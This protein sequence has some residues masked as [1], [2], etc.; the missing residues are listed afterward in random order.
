MSAFLS[1]VGTQLPDDSPVDCT[2]P[3][4]PAQLSADLLR[5]MR[6]GVEREML[7]VQPDGFIAKTAHPPALGS[8][9]THPRIT[10]DY[11]EA[12]LELITAPVDSI[13]ALLAELTELHQWVLAQLP[14]GELLWPLSMPCLLDG[15]DEDI[16]LAQYGQAPIGRL[17]TLYRQGLGLRYGRRMQTIAGVH[18]NLSFGAEFFAALQACEPDPDLRRMSL[19]DY[20]DGRYLGLVRNFIRLTPLVIALVG[21]SPAVCACFLTGRT[22]H[23]QP[24]EGQKGTLTL[25]AA[26]A[27][28][29][30]NLGYQNSTQRELGIHYNTLPDYARA[31]Q[32]A[33][34]RTHSPFTALG[35]DD[36]Q[37][38][39]QQIN[40]HVLQ[41]ENEYY[42]LIRPKQIT[43]P[44]ETPVQALLA[45]GVAYVELRAVDVDPQSAVGVS[46]TTAAWLETL[47]LYALLLPSPPMD[48]EEEDQI[49]LDQ[50]RVVDRGREPGLQLGTGEP[51]QAWM[52]GHLRAMQ[53]LAERLDQA[54]GDAALYQDS[55]AQMQARA[56]EPERW[57]SAQMM[58]GVQA[59]GS[60]W[61]YGQALAAQHQHTLSTQP[62]TD[63]QI[64]QARQQASDSWQ[65]QQALERVT[66]PEDFVQL[67]ARY[68]QTPPASA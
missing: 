3:L 34:W 24:L 52:Q 47:A 49:L 26:T 61:R 31:L 30:G 11:S 13:E 60:L 18:Y 65:S 9:L 48:A 55:L 53:P 19:R 67:V 39:P 37:G 36:A 1:A 68:R 32:Q 27:L 44:G 15:N 54:H 40:D 57:P 20:T 16:P 12:L 35:V 45:R 63:E 4:W 59:A 64:A 23:L 50:R 5:H 42:S 25:P 41:I 10:T 62:L 28:R 46:A 6:R 2:H 33:T 56:C 8:A 38:Q 14:A 21:A 66:D 58:Q 43:Q 29:M 17:K 22:H 7:R 51:L